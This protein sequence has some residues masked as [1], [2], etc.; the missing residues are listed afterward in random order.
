MLPPMFEKI[1]VAN[2]GEVA[3]RVARTCRRIGADTV[4]VH[5]EGED[6]AVHV[7]A[8]DASVRLESPAGYDDPDTLIAAATSTGCVALHPGYGRRDLDP[9]LSYACERAGITFVGPPPEMLVLLRD[10][11]SLRNAAVDAGLRVLPGSERPVRDAAELREDAELLGYPLIIKPAF[12]TAE[13]MDPIV[14][15]R[16]S[17]LERQLARMEWDGNSVYVE[18]H[19]DRPRH[20][21]VQLV[22]DGQG[23]AVVVGDRE[24][25]VRKDQRRVLAE[26]PAPAIDQLH[27]GDAVRSAMWAAAMDLTLS[28]RYRGIASAHFLLDAHGQFFFVGFHPV[29]QPEHAVEEMC[30]NIDL[31][32]L[33]V[34]L[35]QGESMPAEAIRAEP[36]GHA[37]QA[38]VEAATDPRDG[39]PFSAR[40]EDV[41]W[42]PAPTGKVRIET[43]I[44]AGSRVRPEHDPLV[45]SVTT[46]APTRHE[47]VLMLDRIIA[48]TRIAPLTT[49]LRLLRRALNHESFRASQVDEGF[50]ERIGPGQP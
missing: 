29:L 26:S 5:A 48:E 31:V 25:S 21:E 22:G 6:D 42:P 30:A 28:F 27:R 32:E 20:V 18:R 3:A 17:E 39:R 24:V 2:R 15:S 38:L 46:Y 12:G 37:V 4:A 41:R 14:V 40:V 1:L 50:L 34:R 49:N 7:Q 8:C 10:R 33:Q 44:Q 19:L 11:I 43:G 35:A 45:A 16:A 13:A 23:S 47:A 36:S 9:T